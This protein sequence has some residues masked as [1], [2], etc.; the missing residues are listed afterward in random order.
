MKLNVERSERERD[1][2]NMRKLE[3]IK[4]QKTDKKSRE[5]LPQPP[6]L[7]IH[8]NSKC[9]QLRNDIKGKKSSSNCATRPCGQR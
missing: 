4:R 5:E 2:Q 7:K 3:T 1:G 9:I 6:R 8:T